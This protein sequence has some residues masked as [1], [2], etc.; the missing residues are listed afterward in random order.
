MARQVGSR[1][2]THLPVA[3]QYNV[4]LMNWGFVD[5]KTECNF[6]WDSGKY[7]YIKFQPWIWFHQVFRKDGTP[8]LAEETNVIK[9]YN[10]KKITTYYF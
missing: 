6:P 4:G 2:V 8:Y 10:G 5:G 7:P 9:R 1:F 3:K